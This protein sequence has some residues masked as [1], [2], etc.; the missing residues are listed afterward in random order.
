MKKVVL[1]AFLITGVMDAQNYGQKWNQRDKEYYTFVSTGFDVRNL[2]IGSKPTNDK[3]ALDVQFKVGAREN[4]L[5]VSLFYESFNRIDF[6]A[7]GTNVNGVV[8]LY[9]NFDLALGVELGSVIREG[10]SNFLMV[11]TNSEIRLDL[12]KFIVS[13]QLNNRYRGDLI[14]YGDNFPIIHSVFFNI[15][16]KLN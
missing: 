13:L 8:Q 16:Y 14:K 1:L 6:Q 10:N 2:V 11:G 3:S 12:G 4:A 5:E 15:H 9:K 7:Y